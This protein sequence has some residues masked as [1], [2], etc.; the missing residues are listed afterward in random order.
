M[1]DYQDLRKMAIARVEDAKAL[2]KASRFDGAL[3]IVGYA[4]EFALKAKIAS[5]FFVDHGFPESGEEFGILKN[6]QT[7]K[8]DD[9]LKLAGCEQKVESKQKLSWMYVRQRWSPDIRYRRAGSANEDDAIKLIE[10]VEKILKVL[11]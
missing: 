9:L 4:V 1:L 6:L 5:S 7:H 10:A 2:L 3:Y 11:K 8:L